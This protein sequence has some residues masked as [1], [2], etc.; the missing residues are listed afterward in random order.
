MSNY[1]NAKNVLPEK[2]LLQVYE[3]FPG[4]MLYFPSSR[5]QLQRRK[6][7]VFNMF[8]QGTPTVDIAGITGITRRRVNQIIA[9][10]HT[11]I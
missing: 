5:E 11:R 4:G 2:L 3:H 10:K 8:A 1:T 7:I 6:Q 9:E